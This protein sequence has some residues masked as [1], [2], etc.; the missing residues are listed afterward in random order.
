MEFLN[1][2][3]HCSAGYI[4]SNPRQCFENLMKIIKI[5]SP[6][7]ILLPSYIDWGFEHRKV[8]I[9]LHECSDVIP[10]KTF[11]KNYVGRY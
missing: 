11:N 1:Y 7:I 2:M 8:N 5:L 3:K 4:V 10:Y 6:A 9:I